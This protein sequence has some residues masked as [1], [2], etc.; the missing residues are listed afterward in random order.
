MKNKN[1]LRKQKEI[2][3]DRKH[4]KAAFKKKKMLVIWYLILVVRLH[5]VAT[6]II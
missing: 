5:L 6:D 1:K 2:N 4:R 3:K